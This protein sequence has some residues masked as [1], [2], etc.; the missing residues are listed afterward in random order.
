MEKEIIIEDIEDVEFDLSGWR[1]QD[2]AI[3]IN[4]VLEFIKNSQAKGATHL[5]FYTFDEDSITITS[6][7]LT[8][9]SDANFIK[10]KK[11]ETLNQQIKEDQHK[12]DLYNQYL[13][14]KNIFE[15][16]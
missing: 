10:R 1:D 2:K 14:L 16:T 8:V 15:R 7:K 12:V 9:E 11:I 3:P 4:E 13:S 5:Y 6:Q